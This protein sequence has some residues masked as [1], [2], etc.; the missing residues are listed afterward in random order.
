PWA[1]SAIEPQRRFPIALRPGETYERARSPEPVRRSPWWS[2]PSSLCRLRYLRG[3]GHL[4]GLCRLHRLGRLRSLRYAGRSRLGTGRRRGP[5]GL[6]RHL[7]RGHPTHLPSH[8]ERVCRC[9]SS[10][11]APSGSVPAVTWLT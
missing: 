9:E 5:W 6:R 3:L 2:L 1:V 8:L 4:R 7:L 11:E 10:L